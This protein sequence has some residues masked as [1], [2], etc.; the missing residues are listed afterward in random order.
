VELAQRALGIAREVDDRALERY[1]TQR[2][3]N[4]CKTLGDY[5][6]AVELYQR[7]A[8]SGE[9]LE[10]GGES[11]PLSLMATQWLALCLAQ[12]GR[13]PE[14]VARAEQALRIAESMD[15]PYS[16]V[17]GHRAVG[18]VHL[19]MG[20]L[21]TAVP[22]LERAL[23][24]CQT[25]KLSVVFDGTASALGYAYALAGRL[26]D[27]IALLAQA[28]QHPAATGTEYHSLFVSRLS[29][30]YVMVGRVEEAVAAAERA[31][32][33]S[34]ESIERGNEAWVLRLL[35]EI[36]ARRDPLDAEAAEQHYGKALALAAELGMRPLV[37][38]C[39]FGLAAIYRATGRVEQARE[40][41]RTAATMYR[42]M[43]MGC[44]LEQAE[45]A[46]AAHP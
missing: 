19:L 10:F 7:V 8:E 3:A 12:L 14:A 21:E 37:A 25:A 2:L 33:L 6:R 35:G 46:L 24:I 15:H 20:K 30:A 11:V 29:E 43:D 34:R 41:V 38:H 45:A 22:P 36:A 31:L 1:C 16:L 5:P 9:R 28:V 27:G 17:V 39:H 4:A 13:F 26:T 44:Y 32:V 18:F 42:D 40:H 23:D